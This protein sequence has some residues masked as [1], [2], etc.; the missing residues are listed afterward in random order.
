MDDVLSMHMFQPFCYLPDDISSFLLWNLF[1]L[2]DLLQAAIRQQLH[3][4]IE[5]FLIMEVAIE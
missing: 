2:L 1:L 5:V 3:H 4:E